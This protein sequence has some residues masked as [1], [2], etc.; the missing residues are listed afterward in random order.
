MDG[1]SVG[2]MVSEVDDDGSI[3]GSVGSSGWG[4]RTEVRRWLA[5]SREWRGR[6][7]REG[8]GGSES[9][10]CSGESGSVSSAAASSGP[11]FSAAGEVEEELYGA[12]ESSGWRWRGGWMS[13]T[14]RRK[15]G[16]AGN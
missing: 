12:E 4:R 10:F 16:V 11:V 3:D 5:A 1:E 9:L 7:N 8:S 14:G 13:G 6:R 15:S 2:S